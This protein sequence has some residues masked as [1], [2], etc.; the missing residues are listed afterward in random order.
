M[1][2]GGYKILDL[3]GNDFTIGG[4]AI[5]VDGIYEAAEHSYGK[6]LQIAN[7]SLGGVEKNARY[8]NFGINNQN[9]V[10]EVGFNADLTYALYVQITPDDMVSFYQA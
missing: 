9:Y 3:K 2:L 4:S 10:S 1:A 8:C 6:A 7:Y 5:K